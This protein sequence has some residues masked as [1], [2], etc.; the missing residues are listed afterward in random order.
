MVE[1]RRF[2][3]KI[4]RI[5]MGVR[6][7]PLN[8]SRRRSRER[9]KETTHISDSRLEGRNNGTYTGIKREKMSPILIL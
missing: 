5:R 1:S 4:K 7:R 3:A 2:E 6:K 8:A 9:S